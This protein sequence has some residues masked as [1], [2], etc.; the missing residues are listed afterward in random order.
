MLEPTDR[1]LLFELLRPAAGYRL[2]CAIGTTYSLDLLA[3]LVTPLAFTLF[4]LETKEGRLTASPIALLESL[5]RYADNITLFCQSGGIHPPSKARQLFG[6]LEQSVV[7]VA[8]PRTGVFHAKLWI[9]R[10]EPVGQAVSEEWPIQYRLLCPSRNLTFDRSWDTMLALE[11][12]FTPR[13]RKQPQNEPLVRFVSRLPTLAVRP[14]VS[15]QS[16]EQI[17]LVIRELPRVT[18]VP[19]EGFDELRFWP[20][21]ID[22]ANSWPFAEPMDRLLVISPFVSDATIKRLSHAVQTSIVSRSEELM[23]LSPAT[24]DRLAARFTLDPA[25][26]ADTLSATEVAAP[27]E[28]ADDT[29]NGS[30][31]APEPASTQPSV[32]ADDESLSGLHAKVYVADQNGQ[33]RIWTGSANATDAAFG[34]NIEILVELTGSRDVCGG[35]SR[36]DVARI[37]PLDIQTRQGEGAATETHRQQLEQQL[38][39]VM[40]R[41]ERLAGSGDHDGMLKEIRS[42]VPLTCADIEAFLET[43]RLVEWLELA[44]GGQLTDQ[45]EYWKSAPYLLNFMEQYQLKQSF[46]EAAGDVRRGSRKAKELAARIS[47]CRYSLLSTTAIEAFQPVDSAN[48]R[49]RVLSSDVLDGEGAELW[50]LLWL[51]PSVSYYQLEGPFAHPAASKFTKRLIFSSWK[52]VPK[53]I[54][55]AGSYRHDPWI[56]SRGT[57]LAT[58]ARILLSWR[59]SERTG[60]IPPRPARRSIPGRKNCAGHRSGTC[61]CV[62]RSGRVESLTAADRQHSGYRGRRHFT[63]PTG[64]AVSFRDAIRR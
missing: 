53:A 6:Y 36:S 23:R 60:R 57:L 12:T 52:V 48:S 22:E 4:D 58:S 10:F 34:D 7:E 38:R 24:L 21:G 17:E 16:N 9:L 45:T 5:R 41:T 26:E 50:R 56:E 44:G 55:S 31:A 51:P 62:H 3:L 13:G 40:V 15:E 27:V 54:Q 19:P 2:S 33:G 59:A 49:M 1:Q 20:L 29:T 64:D 25:A 28:L 61:R 42:P 39:S 11:G 37:S 18:F 8:P 47:N 63:E 14:P 30:D 43:G 46:D 35:T 32:K